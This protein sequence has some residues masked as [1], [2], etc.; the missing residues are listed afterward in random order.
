MRNS[1]RIGISGATGL[2]GS[3][4]AGYLK[5]TGH[6]LV[7]F[8][9]DRSSL[10]DPLL[11]DHIVN[12][13]AFDGPPDHRSLEGLD[14]FVNLIGAPIAGGRWTEK[15][16]QL[17][18]DSRVIGT[19][20]LVDAMRRCDQPPKVLINGSAVGYY[21][22]RGTQILDEKSR[23][24]EDFLG[25]VCVQWEEEAGKASDLGIRVVLLRT[26]LVLSA[27][28]GALAPMLIPF[29]LGLGGTLGTGEQYMSWIHI[30]DE[31]RLIDFLLSAERI[32]GPVNA[33]APN[34][35]NNREFSERLGNALRRPTFMKTPAFVLRLILGEMA[36]ALLLQGQR[37]VPTRALESGF[38]F[39]YENVQEALG[40]LL[41]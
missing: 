32:S 26:G 16:K 7:L 10:S 18:R 29:K 41:K 8:V 23:P 31:I 9:R 40:D 17:I 20:H 37:V 3:R 27:A 2:I 14:A 28:G 39:K 15:R 38:Q 21:G 19:R 36:E 12:W 30:E 22:S 13:N 34:P 6:P 25:E 11:E 33:T 1:L 4:L 5:A 24:G 35:V